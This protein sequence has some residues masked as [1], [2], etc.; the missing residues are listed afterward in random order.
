MHTCGSSKQW[1]GSWWHENILN[2]W[3][4]KGNG[5]VFDLWKINI[6]RNKKETI[7]G[8]WKGGLWHRSLNKKNAISE[9]R[10]SKILK[11]NL[12]VAWNSVTRQS[13]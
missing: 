3:N 10:W 4:G 9:H 8:T 13:K 11:V 6:I 1:V 5:F 7:E 12:N 2:S